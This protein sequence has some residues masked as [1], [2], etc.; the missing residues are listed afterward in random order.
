MGRGTKPIKA[1]GVL[2][3]Y[4][5]VARLPSPVIALRARVGVYITAGFAFGVGHG[6]T[7][8]MSARI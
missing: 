2:N 3:G 1:I 8:G 4:L 7:L 5:A 6:L